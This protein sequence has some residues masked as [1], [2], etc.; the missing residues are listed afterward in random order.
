MSSATRVGSGS[1][2]AEQAL[3]TADRARLLSR[4]A[5]AGI[6]CSLLIMVA[7][8]SVRDSW[9]YPRIILPAVGPPWDLTFVHMTAGVATVVLWLAILLGVGGVVAGLAAVERGARPS[10]RLLLIAAA[11]A[12]ALLTVFPPAGS[13]D[14]FDYASYGRIAVLGHSPYV[15]TPAQLA[16]LHNTFSRSVPITWNH[17]VSVYG[18]LATLEQFLA[19]KL[20]GI[21][22]ARI[23]FWLKLWNAIAFGLV[24][25]VVDRT[26]RSDPAR[27]LRAHLL[28]TI[29]P[30]L[31][32]NLIAEGHVDLIAAAAGLLGLLVLGEH[33][34]TVRPSLLRVLAAGAL[35]GAAADIK[36]NYAL[37]GLGLIWVLRRSFSA[38][39]TA[40]VGALVV[41]APGYAWFGMPAVH[42][43]S[44]RRNGT[45]ADSYYRVFLES[46]FRPHLA[47]IASL[48]VIAV[49]IL[50]YRRM[51]AGYQT[52][53]VF[54]VALVLSAAWLF[55]WPYQFP[56]YDAMLICLLM[57][58]PATRLDWLVL[59][60]LAIGNL[61]N[62]PGNPFGPPGHVV[63]FVHHLIVLVI[64]PLALFA[65]AI[66]LVWLCLSG[67][68][69]PREPHDPD[70]PGSAPKEPELVPSAASLPTRPF[71][72]LLRSGLGPNRPFLAP[73]GAVKGEWR[74]TG[75]WVGGGGSRLSLHN[76]R[77]SG[78]GSGR[79][80]SP[81]ARSR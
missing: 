64:T 56:W 11:V 12:V 4:L 61:P 44:G 67:R 54:R 51:P 10:V 68:W 66:G 57:F 13:T 26:L 9:M 37:F 71:S 47:E 74:G 28:W 27:R 72:L 29:N 23:T 55:F 19:A 48:L 8:S 15:M 17:F 50:A 39:A 42:A 30:L 32:W 59:G 21:S 60:R 53:P 1:P 78:S 43:L 3:P 62:T 6:G 79:D 80:R 81:A 52:R 16:H 63:Y 45:S 22:A 58:Y 38:L 70:P 33:S 31:L 49:A 46:S 5:V 73:G 2:A 75:R 25:F 18:P 14:A 65:A 34:E 41:I 7:A 76:R 24:A 20:G 40:A 77:M 35:I 36:I 69:N